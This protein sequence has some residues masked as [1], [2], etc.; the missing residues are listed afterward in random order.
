MPW[1]KHLE[2]FKEQLDTKLKDN[3]SNSHS[4]L[5][6]SGDNWLF[7]VFDNNNVRQYIVF[8]TPMRTL[9]YQRIN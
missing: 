1:T 3:E 6:K 5:V 4:T 7:T 8:E 9:G 2:K